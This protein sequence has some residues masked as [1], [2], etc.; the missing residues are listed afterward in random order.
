MT[1]TDHQP[2]SLDGIPETALWT[3]FNRA[4]EAERDSPFVDP[5][6]VDLRDRLVYP[7]RQRFGS[8][9]QSHPL[10][11]RAFDG[12]LAAFLDDRPAGSVVALGEGLQ[13]TYWRLGHPAR[14][15]SV[16]LPEIVALRSRLLP[17]EPGMR[18][19]ASSALDLGWMDEAPT[20]PTIVTAEG[21][22]MYFEPGDALGLI[23]ACAARFPG[24][25]M[26][27]DSIPPWGS[28]LTL[29]GLRITEN[30]TAPPMPWGV[31]VTQMRRL[32]VPGVVAVREV[33]MPSGRGFWRRPV[34]QLLGSLPLVGAHRPALWC[35]QFAG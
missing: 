4:T 14:W 7:Y 32:R 23:E 3:L 30:Y 24:G 12:E 35:V 20:G 8:P 25:R 18:A 27:F 10:R 16:D 1:R 15:L 13:T 5:L 26:L 2:V 28:R 29:R 21:L 11:A 19:V 31:T 9:S 34:P 6:A 33:G 22:L 17:E